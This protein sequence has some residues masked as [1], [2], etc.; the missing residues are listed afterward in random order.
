MLCNRC[1]SQ[2]VSGETFCKVCGQ[3]IIQVNN[4]VNS[5][6]S[7]NGGY[8]VPYSTP[9]K[10][11]NS[12]LIIGI[13]VGIIVAITIV[14]LVAFSAFKV[15]KKS[16]ITNPIAGEWNCKSYSGTGQSNEFI[17]K[18]KLNRN[19]S[20]SWAKYGDE[21][22]NYVEGTYEYKYLDKSNVSNTYDY[23]SLLLDGQ[24]FI[25]NGEIQTEVYS[26]KYEMEVID[27]GENK[28]AL[29]INAYTHNMY[30]CYA[31]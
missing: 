7:M 3:Q 26:S 1:G 11:D 18:M 16:G 2:V 9:N 25:V 14:F 8:Y 6:Y 5:V 24:K 20:F 28:Q 27:N 31:N 13:V 29:L 10:K 19:N 17:V 12:G 30:Y 21:T 22:N 23:Y 15:L 4:N